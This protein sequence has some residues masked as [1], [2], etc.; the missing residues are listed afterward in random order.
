MSLASTAV[1]RRETGGKNS[2][3]LSHHHWGTTLEQF[4]IS[5]RSLA[6]FS[7]RWMNK[8]QLGPDDYWRGCHEEIHAGEGIERSK[9]G[10]SSDVKGALLLRTIM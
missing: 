4:S 5:S 6:F 8:Y 7:F 9:W 1:I 10:R 3:P 2:L